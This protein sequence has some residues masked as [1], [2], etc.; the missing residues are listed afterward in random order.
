MFLLKIISKKFY[1]I[2]W[3]KKIISMKYMSHRYNAKRAKFKIFMRN[4][5][6]TLKNH[7]FSS[8]NEIFEKMKRNQRPIGVVHDVNFGKLKIVDNDF[9]NKKYFKIFYS[10]GNKLINKEK[11]ILSSILIKTFKKITKN[12]KIKSKLKTPKNSGVKKVNK[13]N[14][15]DINN[16]VNQKFNYVQVKKIKRP[17]FNIENGVSDTIKIIKTEIVDPNINNDYNEKYIY[18]ENKPDKKKQT[19]FLNRINNN[20]NN[21]RN[22]YREHNYYNSYDNYNNI[23]DNN[24]TWRSENK[25]GNDVKKFNNYPNKVKNIADFSLILHTN[26]P[27]D[28]SFENINSSRLGSI[29]GNE[30]NRLYSDYYNYNQELKQ[31]FF[32]STTK[33]NHK[34][35]KNMKNKN[36]PNN[37]HSNKDDGYNFQFVVPIKS[38]KDCQKEVMDI[39]SS[40][41]YSREKSIDSKNNNK[42]YNYNGS[43]SRNINKN[44]VIKRRINLN[45]RPEIIKKETIIS[46]DYDW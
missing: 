18:A 35:N 4:L 1:F 32:N 30:N 6:I 25:Y 36:Y 26:N 13:K 21:N 45:Y 11:S 2:Q 9:M 33:K 46:D 5:S 28:T 12:N 29:K 39:Y 24:N 10:W 14:K 40:T 22:S 15:K 7:Q 23:Y 42:K 44:H 19:I 43:K 31:N 38:K 41:N 20:Y 8:L 27:Y 34:N 37:E 17:L 16:H 3:K